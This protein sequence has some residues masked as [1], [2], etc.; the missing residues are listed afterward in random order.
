MKVA[1]GC[2]SPAPSGSLSA[3][4]VLIQVALPLR[5]AAI[6][7]T[8]FLPTGKLRTKFGEIGKWQCC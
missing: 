3:I 8:A 1:G 4:T 7:S 5:Y 2:A 6:D